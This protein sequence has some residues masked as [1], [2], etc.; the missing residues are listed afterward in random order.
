[1][2]ALSATY[3]LEQAGPQSHSYSLEEFVARF[4]EHYDDGQALDVMLR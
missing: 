4:R 3:T 2:G 1:M